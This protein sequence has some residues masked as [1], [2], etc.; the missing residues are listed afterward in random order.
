MGGMNG[1]FRIGNVSEAKPHEASLLMR[2][3]STPLG[4]LKLSN[5]TTFVG[6]NFG[7]LTFG[8]ATLDANPLRSNPLR[9]FFEKR[10]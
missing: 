3:H 5:I 8:R 10:N 4:I 9:L 6:V 7:I 1:N 2:F